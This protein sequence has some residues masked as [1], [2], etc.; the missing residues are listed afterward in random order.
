MNSTITQ[1]IPLKLTSIHPVR[2]D[3]PLLCPVHHAAQ[4]SG[5]GRSQNNSGG[6]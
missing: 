2:N 5:R 4:G 1:D 6:A 3:A